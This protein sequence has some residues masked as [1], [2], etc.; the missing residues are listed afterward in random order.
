MVRAAERLM[1]QHGI[2]AVS[3][4]SVMIEA[5]QR[6][7]SAADY[8][9]GSR[10]GLVAAILDARMKPINAHRLA[11]LERF[12]P[13]AVDELRYLMNCLIVP[14]ATEALSDPESHYARF[15]ARNH[16]DPVL[17][18]VAARSLHADSWR[19]WIDR[20][21][22]LIPEVPPALRRVR[23]D[24]LA[25]SSVFDVADW[26]AAQESLESVAPW[27]SDLVDTCIGALRAP[28]STDT[29]RL[30]RPSRGQLRDA[31]RKRS[32]TNPATN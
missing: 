12:D 17:S 11:M 19:I 14:L 31:T 29:M 18:R 28:V 3:M 1:S 5:G 30:I 24:R 4:R 9:F 22:N 6:N 27:L 16:L 8:Y 15:L 7:K 26:E 25:N 10:D 23:V 21:M 32:G 13:D 2:A 20:I